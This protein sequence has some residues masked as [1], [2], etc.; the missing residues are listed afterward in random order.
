MFQQSAPRFIMLLRLGLLIKDWT[1]VRFTKG[2]IKVIIKP[3]VCLKHCLE[4]DIKELAQKTLT[5]Y[6]KTN[7]K[8]TKTK[9]LYTIRTKVLG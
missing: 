4:R 2:L 5:M 7:N 9:V 6:Q 8:T 3:H 1:S